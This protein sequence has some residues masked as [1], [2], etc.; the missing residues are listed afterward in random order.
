MSELEDAIRYG[1]VVTVTCYRDDKIVNSY[2]ELQYKESCYSL[3]D[4]CV[5]KAYPNNDIGF[6]DAEVFSYKSQD[7]EILRRALCGD[8]D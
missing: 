2:K 5:I 4:N 8:V 7:Y 3:E 6:Y 1:N